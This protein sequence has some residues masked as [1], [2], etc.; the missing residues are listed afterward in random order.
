MFCYLSSSNADGRPAKSPK[1]DT[2]L[3]ACVRVCVRASGI[4]AEARRHEEAAF[5]QHLN[6]H[7]YRERER[8]REIKIAAEGE[9]REVAGEE[10]AEEED[11]WR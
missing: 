9:Q 2:E 11:D 10:E 6:P 4:M 5:K 1:G 8:E 3:P 7:I